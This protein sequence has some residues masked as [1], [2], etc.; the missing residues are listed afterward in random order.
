[1][2]PLILRN[3]RFSGNGGDQRS[4]ESL[5]LPKP[6]HSQVP[7]MDTRQFDGSSL[8]IRLNVYPPESGIFGRLP[9]KR[10][11]CNSGNPFRKKV[12]GA[13]SKSWRS[14]PHAN[15]VMARKQT[16]NPF[17]TYGLVSISAS[18]RA[19]LARRV[20]Q[21]V[22]MEGQAGKNSCPSHTGVAPFFAVRYNPVF[23]Q[24]FIVLR[25]NGLT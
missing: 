24:Y 19:I 9:A 13:E 14:W 5:N 2:E 4:S 12:P 17:P 22:N 15:Q 16:T 7:N 11:T 6:P 1:M 10:A 21:K 23:G 8:V 3:R 18:P 20:V 25:R